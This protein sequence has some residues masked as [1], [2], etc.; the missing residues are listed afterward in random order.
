MYKFFD[1]ASLVDRQ[2][3]GN[4]PHWQQGDCV[5]FVTWRLGDSLPLSKLE[6]LKNRKEELLSKDKEEVAGSDRKLAAF[7]KIDE[8]LN[9]GYGSCLLKQENT[10]KIVDESLHYLDNRL[11]RLIAYVVMPNHVHLLIVPA[12]DLSYIMQN[13]KRYTSIRI[14]KLLGT[15]GS[16]WQKEYFDHLVRSR[17]SFND[18]LD[19]I[20]NNPANLQKGTYSLYFC[21]ESLC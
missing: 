7:R 3:S 21:K 16:L 14:N 4:L 10:R 15:N 20:Q 12:A 13:L 11:Y 5:V 19:Y 1:R 17:R 8:W 9:R 18:I 6:E 2:M